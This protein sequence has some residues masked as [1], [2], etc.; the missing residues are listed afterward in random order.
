MLSILGITP[1]IEPPSGFSIDSNFRQPFWRPA[2][3]GVDADSPSSK[4]HVPAIVPGFTFHEG[5]H[6]HAT[7]LTGD[8]I[9]EVARRARLGHKMKGMGR[10]YDHV[11]LRWSGIR[12]AL[13][14]RFITSVLALEDDERQ[15]LLSWVPV[16]KDIVEKA[17]QEAADLAANLVGR[18]ATP[19]WLPWRA[20]TRTGQGAKVPPDLRLLLVEL[21]GFEPLTS[22]MP[23]KRATSCAKAPRC[24]RASRPRD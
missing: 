18:I 14:E 15:K 20:L 3:D 10:V 1:V 19:I 16:I 4:G 12:E 8:G 9:P 6:A 23:W 13:E 2:W 5:R 17:Q 21:R 24:G 7:W 11:T 22:S